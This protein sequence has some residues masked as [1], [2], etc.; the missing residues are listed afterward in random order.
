MPIRIL[1]AI[2]D[3][4]ANMIPDREYSYHE[5]QIP[6][7]A[8]QPGAGLDRQA[9][10][11]PQLV[12]ALYSQAP[13]PLRTKVLECLLGPVGPLA[14]VSIA[15]GAFS[16]LLQRLARGGIF[17]SFEDVARFSAAHVLELARY[18]E[19]ASPEVLLRLGAMI[20]SNPVGIATVSGSALLLALGS[21]RGRSV[22]SPGE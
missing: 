8:A 6:A 18:V 16:P 13:V 15:A 1:R 3:K 4:G 17:I 22:T 2:Q 11:I 19:Q 9:P 7:R 21:A 20:A 10:D 5:A 14:L 12:S